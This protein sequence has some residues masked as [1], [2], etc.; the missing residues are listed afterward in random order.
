[1]FIL[2]THPISANGRKVLAVA[3]YLKLEPEIK[4]IN[5]YKGE[6]QTPEYLSINPLGKIPS[7]VDKDLV[8]WESNAILQY[9]SEAYGNSILS[10]SSPQEKASIACWLFW[11]SS[12][13]QPSIAN[14]LAAK[15]GHQL[16]PHLVPAP[17]EEPNWLDANFDRNVKFLETHLSNRAYLAGE[18]LT[19]A[20]FSVAGMMTYFRFAKFPFD[21]FPN[22]ARWHERIEGLD[23]WKKTAVDTWAEH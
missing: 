9:I 3:Q 17:S 23:A 19:I 12:H 1:M 18:K 4:L 6:G 5:V 22:I 2:Y 21:K 11:E 20:D 16:V 14:V 7:L 15:V 10:P 8:L 13:W